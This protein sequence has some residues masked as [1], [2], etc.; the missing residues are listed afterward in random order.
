MTSSV[1][2]ASF[3][4]LKDH[5]QN[6]WRGDVYARGGE[7]Q[8]AAMCPS[9]L[10]DLFTYTDGLGEQR[11]F[12]PSRVSIGRLLEDTL[13]L[14]NNRRV[15]SAY[16]E[17]LENDIEN[18]NSWRH[19]ILPKDNPGTIEREGLMF[20][21]GG[22]VMYRRFTLCMTTYFLEARLSES[23]STRLGSASLSF[24]E[25]IVTGYDSLPKPWSWNLRTLD[26]S[27]IKDVFGEYVWKSTPVTS[28]GYRRGGPP[29]SWIYDIKIH[30]ELSCTKE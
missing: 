30:V 13:S 2:Y 19:G 16:I 21:G 11:I 18:V 15:P 29:D 28:H 7:L 24:L 23:E 1:I 25:S 5:I 14:P 26:G 3:E 4:S 6:I 8:Q 17:I 10:E 12:G 20:I 9:E 22:H 27:V